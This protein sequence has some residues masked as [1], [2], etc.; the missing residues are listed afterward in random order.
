MDSR[1]IKEEIKS[2]YD[3]IAPVYLNWTQS[4]HQI[5]LAHLDIMLKQ[6]DSSSPS[7]QKNILE[8]GCGAG[9]PCT[10]VLAARKDIHVTANDISE[11]QIAMAKEQLLPASS[12]VELIQGDMM[13]LEFAPAQFDAVLGMYSIFHLPRDEQTT[14]LARIFHWLKPGG[15]LLANFAAEPFA[16]LS[17]PSWLGGTRGGMHWSSWGRDKIKTIITALGFEVQVDE[18]VVDDEENVAFHWV[19]ARK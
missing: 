10:Q 5:R 4:S 11:T 7:S 19:L 14:I 3:E 17:D 8:L 6:L 12:S 18:V 1:Q 15:L 9:V 13:A 2:A 16:S